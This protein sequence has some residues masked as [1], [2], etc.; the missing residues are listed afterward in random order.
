MS[1]LTLL[2]K[3]NG[4]LISLREQV[5]LTKELKANMQQQEIDRDNDAIRGNIP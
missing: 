5:I 1:E 4:D 3:N 2:K